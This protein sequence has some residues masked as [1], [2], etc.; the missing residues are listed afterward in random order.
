[1]EDLNSTL[2]VREALIDF[3]RYLS[4]DLAP[5]LVAESIDILLR[6]PPHLVANEI[7]A[8]TMT[9]YGRGSNL[10]IS[11]YLFHAVKKIHL[12]SEFRLLPEERLRVYL[13]DL[14]Q[15]LMTFCPESDR[16]ML[17][18]S[19]GRLAQSQTAIVA[20]PVEHLHRAPG[21]SD[22]LGSDR[23]HLAMPAPA[24]EEEPI[25]T[26]VREFNRGMRRF[27]LLVNRFGNAALPAPGVARNPAP[28]V[29][30][31]PSS[32]ELLAPMLAV[33]ANSSQNGVEFQRYL[34]EMEQLGVEPHTD[35]MFRT[36]GQ[37]VPGW[38]I[39]ASPEA[40][41]P[42]LFPV[43]SGPV[44]T[45]H[46]IIQ[47]A[48][49]PDEGAKR[50]GEMVEAAIEQF[51]E[52][53]LGRSVTMFELA[54]KILADKEVDPTRVE[55]IRRT[56]H[57][58]LDP[59]RLRSYAEASEK[60]TLLR[61]VLGFFSAFG[62]DALLAELQDEE[63][64]DRRRLLI[65]L[66][67]VHGAAARALVLDR[68]EA[69]TAEAG[70][71][72]WFFQRNLIYLLRRIPRSADVPIEREI[73]LIVRLSQPGHAL[74]L[75]RE[76]MTSLGQIK[77]TK[78]EDALI[79]RVGEL[80][81]ILLHP[82]EAP[83]DPVDMAGLLDRAVAA[84]ARQGTPRAW[85]AVITHGLKRQPALGDTLA[86]LGDLAAQDLSGDSGAVQRLLKALRDELPR[87]VLG[88]VIPKKTRNVSHIIEAL[89]ATPS[90]EVRQA[91]E[92][93]VKEYHDRE[94]A[95]TATRVLAGFDVAKPAPETGAGM[96]SG[97]LELFGLPSLLQNL[98]GSQVTGVLTVMDRA[99][100]TIGKIAFESGRMA[101]CR[102]GV[103]RG[104]DAAYEL[105][106]KPVPGNF[107]FV[108]RS[109]IGSGDSDSGPPLGDVVP[110]LLEGIRR[111]DEFQQARALVPDDMHL[112]P[113]DVE[114]TRPAEEDDSEVL[115][116]LWA[117]ISQ[118]DS[119]AECEQAIAVDSY[120]IRRLLGHWLEEGSLTPQ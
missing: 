68:L 24:A 51:N 113:T 45:M 85:D 98:A 107:V 72:H 44:E 5:L 59:E 48:T 70:A 34:D 76:V 46:R 1:L 65:E 92:R 62:A 9:Q 80:E 81:E 26:V 13:E 75:I 19:L 104:S 57:Q 66:L 58:N 105:F 20:S 32:P 28:A 99:G 63:K 114:P 30:P 10:P 91:L 37:A 47:L 38:A 119:P 56:G 52:G 36:L 100:A 101:S 43:A 108:S 6:H 53:S 33:A 64:R 87:K 84:L 15:L 82:E 67:V 111:Y 71:D 14:S 16:P 31:G 106:E 41:A 40:G 61:R 79:A 69:M 49:D 11:D 23:R 55:G 102:V 117:R 120:R 86:R 89:A 12:M 115:H 50:F 29:R 27:A 54:E 88:L 103:L 110:I 74:P 97:D 39:Q 109:G 17:R 77:H 2:Q 3:Q 18:G 8:W 21:A 118:G 96:L 93:I 90:P 94:F 22:S 7:Q 25:G 78:V 4:D 112:R 42:L 35:Q 60:H 116:A 95:D 83:Y 73:E